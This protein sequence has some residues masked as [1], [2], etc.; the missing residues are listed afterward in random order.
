VA[1]AKV[2]F[3]GQNATTNSSG[4]AAI[5]V[6]TGTAAGSYQATAAK[7]GYTSA[8]LTEKVS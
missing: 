6:P 7:A 2:T 3:L 1:G 4:A 8:A 5:T